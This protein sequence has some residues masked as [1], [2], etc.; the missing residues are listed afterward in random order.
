MA[1]VKEQFIKYKSNFKVSLIIKYIYHLPFFK[2]MNSKIFKIFVNGKNAV[3][4]IFL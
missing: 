2:S 1:R 4:D 3:I